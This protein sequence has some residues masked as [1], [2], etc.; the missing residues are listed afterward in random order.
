[1]EERLNL[2]K[3]YQECEEFAR[4]VHKSE[5]GIAAAARKKAIGLRASTHGATNA[6]ELELFQAV[7]AYEEAAS[8]KSGRRS[9]AVRT[10]RM[11]KQH[12]I[13]PAAELVV[14]AAKETPGNATLVEFGLSEFAFEAVILRHPESFSPETVLRSR[15]RLR[16]PTS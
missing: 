4:L 14:N 5:P 15:D 8:A 9:P 1:M 2:L 13:I 11:I 7:C 12:G 10:W 16:T 6:V 3:T